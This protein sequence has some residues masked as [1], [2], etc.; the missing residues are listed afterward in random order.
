MKTIKFYTLFAMILAWML[1]TTA[2]AQDIRFGTLSYHDVIDA[3]HLPEHPDTPAITRDKLIEHFDWLKAHG[4]TPVSWQ[5]IQ[6]ARAGR[7]SLPNKA[8]L[9]TF[10]DGY[11][12]FHQIVYP[13]LQRYRY[14]AVLALVTSWMEATDKVDYGGQMLPR[15]RF[16]S[17]EQVRE[18]QKSGLVEIA[19]HSHN[20]HRSQQGNPLGSEFAAALSGQYRNGSYETVA[21]Y[22]QRIEAD[23]RQSAAHIE[24]RVGK[25]PSILVW[26]YGQ[27][28]QTAI[29]LARKVG[30]DSDF[31]LYDRSLNTLQNGHIGRL[32]LDQNSDTAFLRAYFQEQLPKHRTQRIAHIDLD[33]VYDRQPEQMLRN[34]DSV[35]ERVSRLGVST[36][37]LQA[38]ADPDGDGV[39]D[40]MYFPN[41]HVK[42]RSDLFSRVAWQ[43]MQRAGVEVYAWMP[44][45]SV[46]LG[47]QYDYIHDTRTG[48]PDPKHYL[49]L[50]PYSHKSRIALEELYQDLAFHARFN[51]ILF[52]DDGLMTDYEGHIAKGERSEAQYRREAA[53][54]SKDLIEHTERLKQAALKYSYNGQEQMKTARNLYA[55]VIMDDNKQKWFSQSLP[56]FA[57][58]YDYTAIM[59]M[60]YME[61]EQHINSLQATEWMQA[62]TAKVKQSGV[63]LHKIVFELQAVNWRTERPIPTGEITDWMG[64]LQQ[65]GV[66]N[67]G[68]YPDNVYTNHPELHLVQPALSQH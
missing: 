23:L 27:F 18:M 54:K 52:H 13:L 68:Y 19:S 31:S 5:Q 56:E 64:V 61:H 60:P 67:F 4:Y 46:N 38:F 30:F 25:R 51:G 37:Y 44:M 21:E 63:P 50:S 20:L 34:I 58:A 48:K 1:H 62:L 65:A 11:Q 22:R 40:A 66:Q 36:V 53:Q 45:L 35:I 24:R 57:R 59:A 32:M 43:L 29:E 15:N 28:N 47:K 49:R 26:P 16:L 10:D 12:S 9:L 17:W 33:Y 41:R 2:I 3:R 42:M 55:G 6:D 8:V 39:A 7:S 14:P